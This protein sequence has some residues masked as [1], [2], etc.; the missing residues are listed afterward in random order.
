MKQKIQ[1]F[2]LIAAG[3][4]GTLLTF[5]PLAHAQVTPVPVDPD[6]QSG[7]DNLVAGI[8]GGVSSNFVSVLAVAGAI[9]IGILVTFF[10]IRVAKRLILHH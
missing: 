9:M 7:L 8:A 4:M 6:V 3:A 10:A 2:G 5:A 1:K